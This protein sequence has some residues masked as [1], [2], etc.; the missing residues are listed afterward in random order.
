MDKRK[1]LLFL[2]LLLSPFLALGFYALGGGKGVTGNGVAV[3]KGINTELPGAQFKKAEPADKM[4]IYNQADRD[5]VR[6]GGNEIA[7]VAG[8]L[9]FNPADD[10]Q[11]KQINEKLAAIN[12]QIAAPAVPAATSYAPVQAPAAPD[13][14]VSKDVAKLEAMMKNMQ[15]QN[16]GEDPEM[17][18][19]NGMMDKIL[20]IQ[21]PELVRQSLKRE[22][23]AAPDS[24][25]KAIPAVISRDQ[26]VTDGAVVELRLL[27]TVIVNG[28]VIPKNHK[29]Y[30]LASI[31]NQRLNL[32]IRNVGLGTSIIPVNFTVFDA[33]DAMIG[34]NAPE[35]ELGGAVG[36][37]S[38]NA[39][40]SMQ[41][42]SMDQTL[43]VQAAGAG[44][45][46]AKGLLSKK[47]KRIKVKLKAGY[48]LLLRDNTRKNQQ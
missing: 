48:P 16:S 25:F 8:R 29:L 43:G 14:S 45:E 6:T 2:P 13:V 5:S 23:V 20:Q 10:P 37:G 35:A 33:K 27:D 32:E 11:T 31:S 30:G 40:Q 34:I 47:V 1:I 15:Q 4:D 19:L 17:K 26:K 36:T 18:Q 41:F 9:G 39:L 28:Q 38:S 12:K 7:D 42:L 44:I 3:S 24:L 21:N 22:H 46:A